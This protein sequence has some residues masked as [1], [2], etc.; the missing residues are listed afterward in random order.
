MPDYKSQFGIWLMPDCRTSEQKLEDLVATLIPE[1]HPL[2]AMAKQQTEVA[3]QTFDES[4][5]KS[6]GSGPGRFRAV[7]LLKAQ[8]HCWLAW[9]DEP[10]LPFGA[11][12]N[13]RI[14]GHDSTGALNFMDWLRRLY[15][16]Q[17]PN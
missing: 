10:G 13:N 9:Q 6:G 2:W 15:S 11:A 14:L 5:W 1:G 7:D 12:V 3:A 16:L 17:V 4:H 8:L